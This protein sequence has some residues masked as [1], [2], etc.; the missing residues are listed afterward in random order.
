MKRMLTAQGYSLQGERHGTNQDTYAIKLEKEKGL[1][2]VADGMGGHRAGDTASKMA[3]E[4]IVKECQNKGPE[5]LRRAIDTANYEI[6][7]KG[8]TEDVYAGMGTTI[9]LCYIQANKGYIAHVGDSRAYLL[10]N[11]EITR[12]TRDH[13]LVEELISHG[14]ITPEEALTHPMKNII[15]MALG[16]EERIKPEF[17]EITLQDGDSLLLCSDGFSNVVPEEFMEETMRRYAPQESV[18]LL[19]E[20]A[21]KRGSTDDITVIVLQKSNER[22][23]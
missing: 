9:V 3:I 15:T 18:K 10:H 23:G 20:E 21:K 4:L 7:K 11:E 17:T 19:C 1:I 8:M 12:L 2:I 5:A 22:E 14:E 13:S 6:L 16:V